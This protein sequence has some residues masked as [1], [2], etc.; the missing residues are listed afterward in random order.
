MRYLIVAVV[1]T[2]IA[3]LPAA[4]QAA[5]TAQDGRPEASSSRSSSLQPLRTVKSTLRRDVKRALRRVRKLDLARVEAKGFALKRVRAL[6]AGK[7]SAAATMRSATTPGTASQQASRVTVARGSRTFARRGRSTVRLKLSRSGKKVLQQASR[8]TL[9]VKVVFTPR[10][11]GRVGARFKV[12]LRRKGG[13]GGQGPGSVPSPS[14][15][16]P[17]GPIPANARLQYFQTFDTPAPWS[18]LSTQ[19]GHS[20]QAGKEGGDGYA[21]FEVRPGEPLVAGHERC[22]VSYGSF[23]RT[24]P[25]GEYWYRSRMR[26]G[27]GFPHAPI[28]NSWV[29]LQQ[30][31]E[32]RPA[33][34]ATTGTVDGAILVN[35]GPSTRMYIEGDRLPILQAPPFGINAWNEFIVH[36]VWTDQPYGYLEWWINGV[37]KG[38]TNGV[39]SETGGRHFWKGGITRSD[40]IDTL[41]SADISTVEIWRVP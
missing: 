38:R 39:T 7:A 33:P 41:Q 10:T 9:T 6:V 16:V 15:P 25:A 36:G 29:T 37:Y 17:S 1:A 5:T 28:A 4:A 22:E 20:V 12:T 3:V 24:L 13:A 18:G 23:D 40:A 27:A 8:V 2:S 26:A 14:P 21:H 34:G 31:Q 30:W 32:D 19:C 35:S 11:G